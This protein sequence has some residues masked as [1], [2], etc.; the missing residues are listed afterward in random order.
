[1]NFVQATWRWLCDDNHRVPKEVR[2]EC[3]SAYMKVLWSVTA[4]KAAEAYDELVDNMGDY[5]AFM[6]SLG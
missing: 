3:M 6:V 2:K 4:E 1:M 5:P